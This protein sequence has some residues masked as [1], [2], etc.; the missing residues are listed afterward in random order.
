[1]KTF[2][3]EAIS[4]LILLV[5][6]FSLFCCAALN[7]PS[8]TDT[9][10]QVSK[11]VIRETFDPASLKNDLFVIHPTFSR[12]ENNFSLPDTI[13]SVISNANPKKEIEQTTKV[14]IGQNSTKTLISQQLYRVQLLALSNG[15][16]SRKRYQKLTEQLSEPIYIQKRGALFLISAGDFNKKELAT[17]FRDYVI[18]LNEDYSD[19]FVISVEKPVTDI[20]ENPPMSESGINNR[21]KEFSTFG[22]RVLLD[23]FLIPKQANSLKE[24][25][26]S[27]LKRQDVDVIF[28][29]PWYKV[30]VGHYTN[31]N[32]VQVAA[33]KIQ[34]IFPNA[35]KV[36][37]QIILRKNAK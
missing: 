3:F 28:N 8:T 13:H 35:I 27:L 18:E 25:A 21:F 30:E 23:Q 36:R 11:S 26:V 10:S 19:A 20:V 17:D 22:W 31:E 14:L 34:S 15:K 29:A 1:M 7:S 32:S 24:K 5:T 33:E 6:C 12:N 9:K 37:S 16:N 4:Y 2:V